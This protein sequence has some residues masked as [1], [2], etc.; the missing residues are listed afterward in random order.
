[1]FTYVIIRDTFYILFIVNDVLRTFFK[2]IF[3][4]SLTEKYS[5]PWKASKA[6]QQQQQQK[7]ALCDTQNLIAF[8]LFKLKTL[9]ST[10]RSVSGGE[11]Q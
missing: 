3:T 1:M 8:V 11:L 9:T 10:S 5:I 6:S 7:S 4:K 2:Y